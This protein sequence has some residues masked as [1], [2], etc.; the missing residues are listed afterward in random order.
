LSEP[1]LI[2]DPNLLDRILRQFRIKGQIRPFDLSNVAIPVIDIGKLLDIDLTQVVTPGNT[3]LVRVGTAD[4]TTFL[5]TAPPVLVPGDIL[6]SDVNNPAAA[7]VLLDTTR[8]T[9]AP[10]VLHA[11]I[12][13]NVPLHAEFVWRNA[14]DTADLAMWEFRI[15]D[16]ILAEV[17]PVAVNPAVNERFVWRA[18]NAIT[19]NVSSNIAI[20]LASPSSG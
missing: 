13:A 3:V 12:S 8:L 9:A 7:E 1:A 16:D 10:H 14:A 11:S 4:A 6:S 18:A 19:G 20:G 5:P 2:D 15:S 17:G